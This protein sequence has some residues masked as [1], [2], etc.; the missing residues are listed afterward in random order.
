M[1]IGIKSGIPGF[2]YLSSNKS[3]FGGIP[4]NTATLIYGPPK[5]GK[6][7]FSYQF[8]Y[9]GLLSDEPSLYLLTD[10]NIN[11]LVDNLMDLYPNLDEFVKRKMLYIID[12]HKN[13]FKESI[14]ETDVY[15]STTIDNPTEIMIKLKSTI[16]VLFNKYSR[17]RFILDSIDT[18]FSHNDDMLIIRVLKAYILRI[19]EAS[20]TPIITYTEG[21]TNLRCETLLKSFFDNIIVLD[22]EYLTI[23]AMNGNSKRSSP[24]VLTDNLIAIKEVESGK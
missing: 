15:K 4:E 9:Q 7:L 13:H 22:G 2:D 5:T 24:Y 16:P 11:Q 18:L 19:K 14:K 1:I 17:F 8:A 20:G 6:S 21:S 23:E 10:Y 12:A 3:G